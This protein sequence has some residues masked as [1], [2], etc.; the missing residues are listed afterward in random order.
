MLQLVKPVCEM[1]RVHTLGRARQQQRLEE[2]FDDWALLQSHAEEIDQHFMQAIG[3]ASP[4]DGAHYLSGWM[5]EQVLK[6][7]QQKITSNA[8]IWYNMT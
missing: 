3:L 8:L 7:V 6:V 1:L 4:S 5:L 2:L